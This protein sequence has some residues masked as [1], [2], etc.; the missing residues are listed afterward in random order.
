MIEPNYADSAADDTKDAETVFETIT[1]NFNIDEE[2][3]SHIK[4]AKA[5][6]ARR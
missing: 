6:T 3:G 2:A 1:E 4:L 5:M